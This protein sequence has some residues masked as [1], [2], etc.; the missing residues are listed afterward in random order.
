VSALNVRVA[1][2]QLV[3]G[4]YSDNSCVAARVW[5]LFA[6]QATDMHDGY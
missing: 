6:I 1:M 2:M 4:R 3:Y 5:H